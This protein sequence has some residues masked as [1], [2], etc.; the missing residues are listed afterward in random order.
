MTFVLGLTGSMATGK[1]TVLG[2]FRDAGVPTYSADTAVHELYGPG[3]AALGP[4]EALV[5]GCTRGGQVDR[6]KLSSALLENPALL[7]RIEAIVHPLVR[8]K[9]LGFIKAQRDQ[10][11]PLIVLEVPLLFEVANP[12][13]TDAVAVTWCAPQ[14]QRQRAL[15]RPGMT[16]EKLKAMLARQM[17]QDEKRRRADFQLDTGRSLE[18]TRQDVLAVIAACR[19]RAEKGH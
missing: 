17:P 18:Q 8:Q 12:Y 7:A 3:G 16:V 4:L 6:Q 13:P 2:F 1:S 11:T 10:A 9:S 15:A 14:I 5:P 19:L